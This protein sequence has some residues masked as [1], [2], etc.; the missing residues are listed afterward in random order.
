MS[1]DTAAKPTDDAAKPQ[2]EDQESI[3]LASQKT[4]VTNQRVAKGALTTSLPSMEQRKQQYASQGLKSRNHDTARLKHLC[5]RTH[6]RIRMHAAGSTGRR[7]LTPR[8][9]GKRWAPA[10]SEDTAAGVG[11]QSSDMTFSLA[12]TFRSRNCRCSN[13]LPK[14]AELSHVLDAEETYP[15]LGSS[16]ICA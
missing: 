12:K 15:R 16:R 9:E 2:T 10:L 1:K 6:Q 13:C 7:C 11:L 3:A 14:W 8:F 5:T 4:D